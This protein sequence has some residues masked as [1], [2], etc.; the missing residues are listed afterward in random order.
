MDPFTFLRLDSIRSSK[1]TLVYLHGGQRVVVGIEQSGQ[2]DILLST[3]A[4][5]LVGI[6]RPKILSE[7]DPLPMMTNFSMISEM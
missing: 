1:L 2:L 6:S 4:G 5:T 7:F 3:L